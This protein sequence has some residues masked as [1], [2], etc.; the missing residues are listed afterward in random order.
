ML[1]GLKGLP[2]MLRAAIA[3]D[4]W[5]RIEPLHAGAWSFPSL[6]CPKP[7]VREGGAALPPLSLVRRCP[8]IS[9]RCVTAFAAAPRAVGDP[10]PPSCAA[11]PIIVVPIN[12]RL[13]AAEIAYII[14]DSGARAIVV[15]DDLL[16]PVDTVCASLGLAPASVIHFGGR[17]CPAGYSDYEALIGAAS[18][19]EPDRRVRP[20]DPWT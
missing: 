10:P 18:D 1:P 11:A 6:A 7:V 4:P 3:W 2:V 15:Q 16:G 8:H 5:L 20:A 17:R 12:F 19:R 14:E 13:T 9:L